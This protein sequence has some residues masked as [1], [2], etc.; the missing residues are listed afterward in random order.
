MSGW[1]RKHLEKNKYNIIR[2]MKN[3]SGRVSKEIVVAELAGQHE[4]WID[5]TIQLAENEFHTSIKRII[6]K[7]ERECLERYEIEVAKI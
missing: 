5:K 1:L 7:N 4:L 3:S 6:C 2:Y